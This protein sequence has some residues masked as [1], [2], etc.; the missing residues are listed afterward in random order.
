MNST[1]LIPEL[2]SRQF[3]QNDT[4]NLINVRLKKLIRIKDSALEYTDKIIANNDRIAKEHSLYKSYYGL[5]NRF[6][7]C[8]YYQ[9][10]CNIH[11]SP[12]DQTGLINLIFIRP[13]TKQQYITPCTYFGKIVYA[14]NL[15]GS[16]HIIYKEDTLLKLYEYFK[17]L[18]LNGP[19]KSLPLVFLQPSKEEFMALFW[20]HQKIFFHLKSLIP[21]LVETLRENILYFRNLAFNELFYS[22]ISNSISTIL[23]QSDDPEVQ[24]NQIENIKK[25]IL[26]KLHIYNTPSDSL[27]TS[28]Y[29][30][31]R[32]SHSSYAIS[33]V[34]FKNIISWLYKISNGNI[35]TINSLFDIIGVCILGNDFMNEIHPINKLT[36]IKTSNVNTVAK[37]IKDIMVGNTL[38]RTNAD[39]IYA[40]NT[41]YA[42]N[43]A[44]TEYTLKEINNRLTHNYNN[45]LL[46]DNASGIA[47]NISTENLTQQLP[48]LKAYLAKSD[49]LNGK[50]S[51]SIACQ[52]DD[53]FGTIRYR[54]N[55]HF[56][57][58][59]DKNDK[60]TINILKDMDCNFI[61][62]PGNIQSANYPEFDSYE[63][64]FI[65]FC[66]TIG[67][68][69]RHLYTPAT[70]NNNAAA[71]TH[72]TTDYV[73]TANEYMV[74]FIKN[75]FDAVIPLPDNNEIEAAISAELSDADDT[76]QLHKSK[77]DQNRLNIARV[78]KITDMPYIIGSE[79]I[80]IFKELYRQNIENTD[81]E[82][83]SMLFTLL[84][85]SYHLR[86]VKNKKAEY[87]LHPS[88]PANVKVI[89]GLKFNIDKYNFEKERLA[90]ME[91]EKEKQFS[92]QE[93]IMYIKNLIN[94]YMPENMRTTWYDSKLFSQQDDEI[95]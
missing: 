34:K 65:A 37:F 9:F 48:V 15:D 59:V 53:I 36:V 8:M 51:D 23:T 46:D 16:L 39:L 83:L 92:Q 19:Y 66:A 55:L 32:H 60:K 44:F 6:L 30:F 78:L 71:D 20:M 72:I 62:L 91:T 86:Y 3:N 13:D 2:E 87:I 76:N 21:P 1:T 7:S 54:N 63:K 73:Q 24:F 90:I 67:Y 31:S 14:A 42:N 77:Y 56:L 35:D 18:S 69:H 38:T 84:N 58:I 64:D 70:T 11:I 80:T 33:S 88:S 94:T 85:D 68:I 52:K 49:G 43:L 47:A 81:A 22:R 89:Y 50:T 40:I 57:H 93:F 26:L 17:S 4:I 27:N 45:C 25:Y 82:L 74:E 95:K 12:I 10:N 5:M 75:C 61:D 28:T 29:I 79:F 41:R